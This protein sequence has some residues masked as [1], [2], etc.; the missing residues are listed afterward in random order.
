MKVLITGGAGF[1]GFHLAKFLLNKGY[2]I[3]LIDNFYRGE[4]DIDFAQLLEN[5]NINFI[6]F[7]LLS[8]KEMSI[9]GDD[10]DFIIHLAAIIGVQN[11][12]KKPFNVLDDNVK[13][14]SNVI[15]FSRKQK[16]LKKFLFASTSEVYA[17]TLANFNLDIPTPEH[18][19]L[20]LSEISHPRTTYMLS[21]IYGEAMCIHS[22]LP[23]VIFRP[24]NF[25]GPR[26]GMSHLIPEQLKKIFLASD[27]DYIDVYSLEHSRTFCYI[28]D[29]IQMIEFLIS[30]SEV[31]NDTFNLG[32]SFPEY[33]IKEVIKICHNN[34]DKSVYLREA[35]DLS[36]SP[37]RRAPKMDKLFD[38]RKFNQTHLE[39]GV[40]ETREWYEKNYFCALK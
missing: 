6:D 15:A 10:I 17:G 29:A 1:I 28:D 25:Y 40:K 8:Q 34:Q 39:Q 20:A 30:S 11:V 31:L 27:G 33:K 14:L 21:K 23:Y 36:A 13:M 37:S 35:L 26:M 4:K 5:K 19:P 2:D 18:S 3:I 38:M 24:H 9:L 12:V 32:W 7:D 16:N 22:G